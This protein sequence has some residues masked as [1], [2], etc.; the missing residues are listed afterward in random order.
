MAD[1]PKRFRIAFSFAG[2]KRD[3]VEKAALLLAAEFGEHAILYDKYHEAEFA[4]H[5]LGI[6]LPKLYSDESDLIVAVFSEDYDQKRWTGWEWMGIHAQLTKHDGSRIMLTRFDQV[7]PDGLFENAGFVDLDHKT[8]EQTAKLILE[9]LAINEGHH[10]GHHSAAAQGKFH[11]S[12]PNNLPR[13]QPFFGRTKELAVV[14]EAL[15]PESRTWG[16]LI[17]GPGGMGKTSLAVRAAY[18][19][20]PVQFKRI[21]F[22]S[23][24]D[25]EM[26]DDGPR[27]LGNLLIP[28]FLAML[29][30]L[31]R[32]LGHPDIPKAAESE[33]IRLLLDALRGTRTLLILDN[34]ETLTK[35][36]RDELFTFVKRLPQGC[37][38]ILTSRRRIGSSADTLILEKLDQDAALETLAEMAK[39]NALLEKMSEAERITLYKQTGGKPLLLRWT[40][41]QLGRGHCRT[42][43]EALA[44]LRSCPKDNDPLEFI[45]GDLAQEF[46]DDEER[47]LA[48][49]TYFTL[50]AKVEHIAAVASLEEA[51]A[52]KALHALANRSL[53][54]PDQEEKEYALVPLVA[55]FLRSHRPEAVRTTGQHLE[56]RAY[57]L[58]MENGYYEH[59]HFPVLDAAWPSVA[60]A[61]SL[62]VAG[63]N[64][65]L[66]RVCSALP[67]FLEFTGRWDEWLSL[68]GQAEAKAVSA[69]DYDK[70]GWR[71]YQLGTIFRLRQQSGDVLACAAR[72]EEHWKSA[73]AGAR[74]RA[75]AIRLRGLGHQLNKDYPAAIAAF[76]E[77]LE[78]DRSLS[79]E[80]KDVA[81]GLNSLANAERLSGDYEV[82][83]RDYRE[84][85]RV[86]Q[87]VGY[88]EGVANFT[89]NLAALALDREDWPGAEA[90]AREALP[91]SEKV[92]RLELIAGDCDRLAKALVRQGKAAEALPHARRAVE[93]YTPLGSA[94]LAWA[95]A[96]L[97]ECEEA[98]GEG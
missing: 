59:A 67:T 63:E 82:A 97:R 65:R 71:A 47:A 14:R 81:I 62:F 12:I 69:G 75:V 5:D 92:G 85:L 2:E 21:L 87:A 36:D 54:T 88:A 57:A 58:I 4:R 13:L 38:A 10:K 66:Q 18:D 32:E 55:E 60:P 39:R 37:K 72:A 96:T 11:T 8:P 23:I 52:E 73:D 17:D 45:F 80:S 33:R 1:S 94:Y 29:N 84:A 50:P 44:F 19:C 42:F 48:S 90:L 95:E 61:I 16:A 3:F 68:S 30:E 49:L 93:L 86:A 56:E 40:A 24:K 51:V 27:S 15:D 26:E 70:A 9:R 91:L 89:G 25:R 6:Y 20:P 43:T 35:A 34:L 98:Q 76:R 79:A 53:V 64:V 74:E 31:A 7:N 46:T 78:L 28:G 22:V 83:E 41:G 77:A